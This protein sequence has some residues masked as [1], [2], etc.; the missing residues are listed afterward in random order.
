MSGGGTVYHD[1]GNLNFSFITSHPDYDE[2]AYFRLIIRALGSLGIPL[3]L[4]GRKDLVYKNQKVSGN[5]FYLRGNRRLH[6]GTL[7]VDADKIALWRYLS[8]DMPSIVG[9]GISSTRSEVINL[10]EVSE[11]VTTDSIKIAI[12]DMFQKMREPVALHEGNARGILNHDQMKIYEKARIRHATWAWQ[13]GET[14]SFR[15]VFNPTSHAHVDGGY[16]TYR[17]DPSLIPPLPHIKFKEEP[18]VY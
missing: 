15:Y 14:P 6:H 8:H 10:R 3:T 9:K 7:L 17:T 11:H 13:Y 18:H 2:S 4:N 12:Q 16:V 5:A 1:L